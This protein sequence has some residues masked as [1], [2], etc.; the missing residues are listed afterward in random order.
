LHCIF[1]LTIIYELC[2]FIPRHTL[3]CQRFSYL[4]FHEKRSCIEISYDEHIYAGSWQVELRWLAAIIDPAR[5]FAA[6]RAAALADY[7]ASR[8]QRRCYVLPLNSASFSAS[9]LSPLAACRDATARCHLRR[10]M[11]F[12]FFSSLRFFAHYI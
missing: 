1:R 7:A 8:R 3:Y 2:F 9:Q 12:F 11:L 6:L 5:Y 10:A 4:S